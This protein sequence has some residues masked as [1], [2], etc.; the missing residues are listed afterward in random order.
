MMPIRNLANWDR[1]LRVGL[2]VLLLYAGFFG[3]AAGL[4]AAA[5]RIFFW[6]PL[7]TGIVGWSPVY[8]FF[9]WSTKSRARHE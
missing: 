5:C 7:L 9:G 4:L 6:L 1:G 2:G 3:G 8:S